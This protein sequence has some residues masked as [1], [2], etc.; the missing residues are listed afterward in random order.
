[1]NLE[2]ITPENFCQQ[3][4]VMDQ[5]LYRFNIF[6]DLGRPVNDGIRTEKYSIGR[7]FEGVFI[8]SR[9]FFHEG[10]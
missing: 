2:K 9:L 5:I 6:A 4:F 8:L 1:V 10:Q 3:Y 7:G